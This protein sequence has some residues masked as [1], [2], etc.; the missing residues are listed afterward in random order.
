[1]LTLFHAAEPLPVMAMQFRTYICRHDEYE[2][3][4]VRSS[5]LV[6]TLLMGEYT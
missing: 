2:F 6:S 5:V 4:T 1:M 3:K